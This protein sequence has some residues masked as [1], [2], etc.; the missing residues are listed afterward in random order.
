VLSSCSLMPNI[1][2]Q[3]PC[4]A[5]AGFALFDLAEADVVFREMGEEAYRAYQAK[6]LDDTLG[7]GVAFPFIRRLLSL[8]DLVPEDPLYEA[9]FY[10]ATTN[11]QVTADI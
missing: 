7:K 9:N 11:P 10:R 2:A 5:S 6:H 1:I 3:H 8:N 4:P